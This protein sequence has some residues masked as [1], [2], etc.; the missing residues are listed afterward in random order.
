[1]RMRK[2]KR[3]GDREV[4]IYEAESGFEDQEPLS[5]LLGVTFPIENVEF[6]ERSL[7]EVAIVTVNGQKYYTFSKVLL[8]QLKKI[9]EIIDTEGLPVLVKLQRKRRY[10]TFV[11]PEE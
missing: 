7:G 3:V 1:M 8:S 2:I 4:V 5:D 9:K 6:R 10:F 11:N